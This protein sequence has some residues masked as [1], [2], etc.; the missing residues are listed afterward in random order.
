M[1]SQNDLNLRLQGVTSAEVVFVLLRCMRV[2][3][4]TRK[5]EEMLGRKTRPAHCPG[6]RFRRLG[7][8]SGASPYGVS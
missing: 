7:K 4:D 3:P 5:F 8:F 2:F 1:D 6:R